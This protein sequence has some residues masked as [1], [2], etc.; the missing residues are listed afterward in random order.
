MSQPSPI[1]PGVLGGGGVAPTFNPTGS[2]AF[3]GAFGGM[4]PGQGQFGGAAGTMDP[5]VAEQMQLAQEAEAS[6]NQGPM[7]SPMGPGFVQPPGPGGQFG[8]AAGTMQAA[9]PPFQ[10]QGFE[11]QFSGRKQFAPPPPG[12]PGGISSPGFRGWPGQGRE[13]EFSPQRTWDTPT[14]WTPP[15]Q[16]FEGEFSRQ[17]PQRPMPD[18]YNPELA[19][20]FGG[21][22]GRP[23]V[24]PWSP[25]PNRTPPW[26]GPGP[27]P[28]ER[29]TGGFPGRPPMP[30]GMLPPGFR[31][32]RPG[33]VS[34]EFRGGRPA[35]FPGGPRRPTGMFPGGG[36]PR[37]PAGHPM[38]GGMGLRGLYGRM[39]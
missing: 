25:R 28:M 27:G 15:G 17:R 4:D 38:G 11:G 20:Q 12:S 10:G 18:R 14:P 22:M 5:G 32:G 3:G 29:P 30:P 19:G 37:Y 23:A 9:L 36:P 7:A 8:G 26:I 34:P 39:A 2:G 16:G 24:P 21:Q 6:R 35:M 33:L 1:T 13:G 31:R